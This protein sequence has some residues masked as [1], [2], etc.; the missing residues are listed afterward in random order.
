MKNNI[1]KKAFIYVQSFA[2]VFYIIYHSL[3]KHNCLNFIGLVISLSGMVIVFVLIFHVRDFYKYYEEVRA[4]FIPEIA[5]SFADDLKKKD[6]EKLLN[7]LNLFNIKD[8]KVGARRQINNAKFSVESGESMNDSHHKMETLNKNID[9]IGLRFDGDRHILLEQGSKKFT[10]KVLQIHYFGGWLIDIDKVANLKGE[11]AFICYQNFLIDVVLSD[12]GSYYQCEV[13]NPRDSDQMKLFLNFMTDYISRFIGLQSTGIPPNRFDNL[14]KAD[15]DLYELEMYKKR[16]VLAYAQ[17]IFSKGKVPRVLFSNPLFYSI[18]K[19]EQIKKTKLMMNQRQIPLMVIDSFY[20]NSENYFNN[21]LILMNYKDYHSL[22]KT[23]GYNLLFLYGKDFSSKKITEY[24]KENFEDANIT[25]KHDAIPILKFQSNLVYF[26]MYLLLGL[27]LVVVSCILFIRLMK[28]YTV[29]EYELIFFKIYGLSVLVF[30]FMF[31]IIILV[32]IGFSYL[33]INIFVMANNR[34]LSAYYYPEII[35]T[36]DNYSYT[37]FIIA[38]IFVI[39]SVIEYFLFKKL[40]FGK[41]S[42]N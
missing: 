37:G 22:F 8:I 21:N 28:F 26:C 2:R 5:V 23:S 9:I 18:A 6:I 3:L 12:Y 4:G 33:F 16:I 13:A 10:A 24:I 40:N 20:I 34:L 1:S 27:F 38:A 31:S 35:L 19:Y 41:R 42:E 11:K 29:F 7:D 25:M 14:R 39:V 36:K 32:S 17:L 15:R 30:S